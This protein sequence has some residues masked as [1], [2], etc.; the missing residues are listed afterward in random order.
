MREAT[1]REIEIYLTEEGRAPFTE[2]LNSLRDIRV[3]VKIR[4]RLNRIRL[5]NFGDSTSVGQ[6]VEE[7]RIDFGPGYRVYYG[8]ASLKVV[9]LLCGGDK[10]TQTQDVFQ[11]KSYWKDYKKRSGHGTE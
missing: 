10:S 1:E 5:G 3:R 9:L 4:T 7:L 11:A 8:Q 6:G 2:W